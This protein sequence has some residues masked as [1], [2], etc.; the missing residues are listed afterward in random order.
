MQ[1]HHVK[2]QLYFV[3]FHSELQEKSSQQVSVPQTGTAN[4]FVSLQVLKAITSVCHHFKIQQNVDFKST[5]NLK[6]RCFSIPLKKCQRVTV[7]MCFSLQ[8]C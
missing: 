3:F 4:N 2:V 5:G 8:E 1:G 7:E 6:L